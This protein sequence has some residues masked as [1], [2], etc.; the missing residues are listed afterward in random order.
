VS[1]GRVDADRHERAAAHAALQTQFWDTCRAAPRQIPQ[2]LAL[3]FN[4]DANAAMPPY[5]PN[6]GFAGQGRRYAATST[7]CSRLLEL[8][9]DYH[10]TA[11]NTFGKSSRQNGTWKHAVGKGWTTIDYICTRLAGSYGKRAAPLRQLPVS[12]GGY[13]DHRPVETY[14][15]AGLRAR[16]QPEAKPL[17]WNR[18]AIVADLRAL[19]GPEA[20]A[21]QRVPQMRTNLA[22]M[23]TDSGLANPWWATCGEELRFATPSE[24]FNALT[25]RPKLTDTTLAL[26]DTKH[27]IQRRMATIADPACTRFVDLQTQYDEAAKAAAKAVRSE[28]RQRFAETAVEAEAA[29]ANMKLRKLHGVVRRLAPKPTAPVIT[30]TSPTTAT[31][32]MDAEEETRVRTKALCDIFDGI[33]INMDKPGGPPGILPRDDT[34]IGSYTIDDFAKAIAKMPNYKSAPVLKMAPDSTE[35]RDGS[36]IELWKLAT[37]ETAPVLREFFQA[38]QALGHSAQRFKDG[39]TASLRK[40]KGDGK[41]ARDHYRT[42]NLINHIGKVFMNVTVMPSLRNLASKLSTAQFGALAGR[43]TRGAL[44]KAFDLIDRDEIWTALE[45]LALSREVRLTVEELHDGTCYIARDIRT[46]RPIKKLLIPRGVRRGSVEGPLLFIA[47]YDLL[48][49][50]LEQSQAKTE[51]P[52]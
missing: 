31:A 42:I 45:A 14:V 38:S 23:M 18:D 2:R 12:L 17:R 37:A 9:Q 10:M 7:N 15:Y 8:L 50:K 51:F 34:R 48:T 13:R 46:N 3:T 20:P 30:V 47:V 25:K 4:L 27:T 43:S 26:I 35:P 22:Q 32:C 52:E 24:Y 33:L 6:V 39:E 16:R 40:P 5:L 49:S 36:V 29:D 28:R 41:N 11:L 1:H 19:K 21:P 44:A